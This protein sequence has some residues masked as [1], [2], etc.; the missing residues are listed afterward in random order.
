A[1]LFLFIFYW[2]NN[3]DVALAISLSLVAVIIVAGIVGTF[4]PLFL[5][6]RGIDPAIATGPFITTS[7]DIFG[8]LI[9]F[10]IA[11]IILQF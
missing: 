9:Y 2:R 8:I 1:I 3:I 10:M 11:K 6:K 7:N 4:I 5:N